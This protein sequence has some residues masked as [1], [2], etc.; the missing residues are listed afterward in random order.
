M[1]GSWIRGEC[2]WK[3]N[4][5]LFAVELLPYGQIIAVNL[6]VG[7]SE[8][9]ARFVAH[10]ARALKMIKTRQKTIGTIGPVNL[11]QEHGT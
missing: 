4:A 7:S 8:C 2:V 11:L 6:I 5:V 3:I 1:Y 9:L 10:R